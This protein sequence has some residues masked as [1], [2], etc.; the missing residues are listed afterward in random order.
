VISTA[1]AAQRA[2]VLMYLFT[3]S[4]PSIISR[5]LDGTGAR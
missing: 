5:A 4:T 2:I 3:S 1:N